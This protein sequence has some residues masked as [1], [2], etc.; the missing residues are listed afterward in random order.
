[1]LKTLVCDDEQPALELVSGILGEIGSVELV[2]AC[3]S[4]REALD[5][6]NRGGIELAFFDIEMPELKGVDAAR[7]ISVEPRPLIVFAT[8]HADYAIEAFGVDAIDYVLK[9]FDR[10]RIIQSVRKAERLHGVIRQ[11]IAEP[12]VQQ[13]TPQ[14]VGLTEALRI[15]D[16]GRLHVI[17]FD[18]IV[19]IEAAG[20]YSLVHRAAGDLAVRRTIS[21]LE[22]DLP[23]GRFRR[24]HRSS[25]VS[26]AHIRE[27]RRLSRG[28]GEI[29][30][31]N[32]AIVRAS[33]SHRDVISALLNR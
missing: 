25:I 8:A 15:V 18:D 24:V 26:L 1:M 19:W 13:L 3:Q 4:A 30:L 12:A 21:S 32:G 2:A 5:I 27:I 11:G 17:A 20:D 33:R 9:P 22:D 6:I 10:Q 29:V 14:Q 31:S 23:T 16:A 7:A 28:E